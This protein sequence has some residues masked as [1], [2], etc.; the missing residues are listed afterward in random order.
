MVSLIPEIKLLPSHTGRDPT[1]NLFSCFSQKGKYQLR[2]Y[3]GA[4]L[5]VFSVSK[6][7]T[8]LEEIST[9][10]IKFLSQSLAG[11]ET[12]PLQFHTVGTSR[13][14]PWTLGASIPGVGVGAG[15]GWIPFKVQWYS[16]LSS[17]DGALSL[18]KICQMS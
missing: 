18:P 5:R 8:V 2:P 6:L 3:R 15:L 1:C 17:L 14:L 7:E 4:L 9:A 12:K 10:R 13:D 11:R 16:E